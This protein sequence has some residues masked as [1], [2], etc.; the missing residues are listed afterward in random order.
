MLRLN[1]KGFRYYF[2][3]LRFA[4]AFLSLPERPSLLSLP[5]GNLKLRYDVSDYTE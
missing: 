5:G 3:F 2:Y 1:R 4:P